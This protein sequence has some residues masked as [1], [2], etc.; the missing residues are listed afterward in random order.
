MP[1]RLPTADA[2]GKRAYPTPTAPTLLE[3]MWGRLDEITSQL[4]R[5]YRPEGAPDSL[6]H[7]N[8]TDCVGRER[9]DYEA[10]L[11][12]L[13]GEAFG[14]AWAISVVE[15]PYDPDVDA[16]RAKAMV[17]YRENRKG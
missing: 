5:D 12:G 13:K 4:I 10:D 15:T 6:T 17:R 1:S 9:A 16:V 2:E 7:E 3:T 11:A 8:G 14:L